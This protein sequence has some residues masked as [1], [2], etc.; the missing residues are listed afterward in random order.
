MKLDRVW[1]AI[2]ALRTAGHVVEPV[3][4]TDNLF[5][6]D[7]KDPISGNQVLALAIQMGLMDP[8]PRPR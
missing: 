5:R 4:G 1:T 6:V 8:P 7:G 3:G 2:V